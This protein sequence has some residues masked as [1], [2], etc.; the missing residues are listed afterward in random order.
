MS[1]KSTVPEWAAQLPDDMQSWDEVT[2][3]ETADDFYDQMSNMRSRMGDS[4]RIPSNEASTEDRAA[5]SKKL[6]DKVPEL[7]MRPDSDEGW[8]EFYSANGRPKE[9]S[10]Y[11]I[12]EGIGDADAEFFRSA[13]YESGMSDKAFGSFMQKYQDANNQ[14]T[15]TI[16]NNIE[17]GHAALKEQWGMAYDERMGVAS[18]ILAGFP[19]ER[20]ASTI[21]AAEI[22]ALYAIG[23]QL[24]SGSSEP[25]SQGAG[26]S[27]RT[28]DEAELMKREIWDNPKHPYHHPEQGRAYDSAR[29]LMRE[30]YLESNA[31]DSNAE[32]QPYVGYGIG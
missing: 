20:D 21:P 12:P 7:L 6:M 5:F 32:E 25:L 13:L 15:E 17:E 4:I 16:A 26:V 27:K 22:E 3:S 23:K 11:S 31:G 2:Q 24:G 8:Q 9:A 19:G 29:K 28:P 30:L 18:K 14:A 1:E 10:G